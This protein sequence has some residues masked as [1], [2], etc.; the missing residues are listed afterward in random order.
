MEKKH[1]KTTYV[2]LLNGETPSYIDDDD[3]ENWEEE[4]DKSD[5]LLPF[6]LGA[7]GILLASIIFNQ[8]LLPL[9]ILPYGW[10]CILFHLIDSENLLK[11]GYLLGQQNSYKYQKKKKEYKGE[12]AVFIAGTAMNIH[13][14]IKSTKEANNPDTWKK[15]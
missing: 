3:L 1:F 10:G 5:S 11:R 9:L 12:K 7:G 4:M 15:L 13:H 6:F 14:A 2:D 8:I